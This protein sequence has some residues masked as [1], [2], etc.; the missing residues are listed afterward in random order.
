[1][2]ALLY[3]DDVVSQKYHNNGKLELLTSITLTL[4]SNIITSIINWVI[5]KLSF[6]TEYLTTMTENVQIKHKYIKIFQK[7]YKFIKLKII[8]FYI[9]TFIASALM[10]YY[11]FVFC[12]IYQK[13]QISLLT[14]FC[15]G[16]LESLLISFGVSLIVCILRYFGLKLKLINLY[17]TSVYL[18]GKN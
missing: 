16:T 10:T 18:D 11:L 8:C 7:L 1:M 14:N 6:Y 2:N 12:Y 9:T 13:S 17:R 4:T 3:S 15:L 5:K